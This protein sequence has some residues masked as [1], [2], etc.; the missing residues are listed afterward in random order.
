MDI[1]IY[2]GNTLKYTLSGV[3]NNGSYIWTLDE[4]I[5]TGGDWRIKISNSDDSSEYDWS[6][7][8]YISTTHADPIPGYNLTIIISAFCIISPLIIK[9]RFKRQK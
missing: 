6:D 5:E 3:P 2:K 7:Y 1:D 9:R 4:G 8:F